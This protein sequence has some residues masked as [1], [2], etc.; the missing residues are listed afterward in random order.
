MLK[1][2]D[3]RDSREK[4]IT[5]N[6]SRIYINTFYVFEEINKINPLNKQRSLANDNLETKQ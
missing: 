5:F 4:V 3:F 1:N 6:C 2:D